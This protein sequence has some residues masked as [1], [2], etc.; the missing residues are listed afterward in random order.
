VIEVVGSLGNRFGALIEVTQ[1]ALDVIELG[2][3]MSI[4]N[5]GTC[6]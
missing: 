1:L 4:L 5:P 3:I 2:F 6:V